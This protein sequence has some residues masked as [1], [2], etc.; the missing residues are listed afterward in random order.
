L[1]TPPHWSNWAGT[2]HCTPQQLATPTTEAEVVDLVRQA[3][4][5]G[6]RVRVAGSGHSF[7]PLC[8]TEE[9]LISLDQLQGLVNV[10]RLRQQ[11][12]IWAGSKLYALGDLLWEHGLAMANMGDIDRQTLAGAISTGTHGTGRT[13]GSLST[14]VVGIRLVTGTGEVIEYSATREADLVK[15]AAVSLGT[16]GVITQI[17]LQLIPAYGLHERTWVVPFADCLAQLTDQIQANRH[18]EFFWVPEADACAMKALNPLPCPADG[19]PFPPPPQPVAPAAA[20]RLTRYVRPA[21]IDRSYRIFPSER[22]LKFRELEFALPA[23]H[24]PPCLCE[25]RQLMQ[26]RYADVRWPIE[27]R[28]LAAD[29]LWLSPAYGRE[30]VTIS[31]H[32]AADLPYQPFFDDVEAIFRTH[33]G[34]PHWGKLHRHTVADLR[35][36]YPQWDAFQALRRQLDPDDLFLNPHLH[37]LFTPA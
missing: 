13:L 1:N 31:I 24:G 2:I 3:R 7:T 6:Q 17:T 23:T 11:A 22:T 27:Y 30:T 5:N 21:Q 12:T 34:R 20:G 15:A 4:R 37:T 36:H 26:R 14:Q 35:P 29:D 10:D 8:A 32:Q 19:E 25:V 33:A 18:F 28:T 9:L 16:L